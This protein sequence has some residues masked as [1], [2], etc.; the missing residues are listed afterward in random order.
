MVD[1]S[2]FA[3]A[4]GR[5]SRMHI[6]SLSGTPQTQAPRRP[7]VHPQRACLS[8]K[9]SSRRSTPPRQI[10]KHS[11]RLRRR[12]QLKHKPRLCRIRAGRSDTRTPVKRSLR[13]ARSTA[14]S[15]TSGWAPASWTGAQD[16]SGRPSRPLPL[17]TL[18]YVMER[19]LD[20]DRGPS[21]TCTSWPSPRP[22]GAAPT[23]WC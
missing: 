15:C 4:L 14:R 2:L 13:S 7:T 9:G 20:A 12:Y 19:M 23:T 8:C 22:R 16:S 1:T 5:G 3:S 18:Q 6:D 10:K 21:T 17:P 11:N